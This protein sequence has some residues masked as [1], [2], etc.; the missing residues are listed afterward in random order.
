MSRAVIGW[1]LGRGA[2]SAARFAGS[3]DAIPERSAARPIHPG[4]TP[5]D[6][7]SCITELA[8]DVGSGP[9]ASHALVLSSEWSSCF[10]TLAEAV[11]RALD[12]FAAALPGAQ[13]HLLTV[14]GELTPPEN[15]RAQP[16]TVANA[17]WAAAAALA[18]EAYPDALYVEVGP[19]R[20]ELVP[21]A[22]GSIVAT[23]RTDAERLLAGELLPTGV[24]TSPVESLLVEV[25]LWDGTVAVIPGVAIT[26]DVHVWRGA[27]P[28]GSLTVE[29]QP[30]SHARAGQR[31]ARAVGGDRDFIDETAVGLIASALARAQ[32]NRVRQA[33]ERATA[34]APGRTV[35]IAGPGAF[36]ATEA[37]RGL[38]LPVVRWKGRPDLLTPEA[39]VGWL[40]AQ[41]PND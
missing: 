16:L 3:A 28:P 30:L 26:A 20:T 12:G 37:T 29:G 11:T 33:I 40:L 19:G 23:G 17:S 24:H 27:V 6:L 32:V 31:L 1:C 8:R 18:G 34:A 7:V 25:P 35:L 2:A 22:G 9:G 36:V 38:E 13:L 4:G 21:L 41:E 10:G 5:A 14:D 15:A 39:A